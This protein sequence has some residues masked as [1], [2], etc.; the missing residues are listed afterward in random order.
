[1]YSNTV[2]KFISTGIY[3]L[4]AC[5]V[6]VVEDFTISISLFDYDNFSHL[7]EQFHSMYVKFVFYLYC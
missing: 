2:L 6:L 4:N 7:R 3:L 5:H 1:M